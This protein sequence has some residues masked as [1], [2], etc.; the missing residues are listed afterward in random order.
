MEA[1]KTNFTI[2]LIHRDSP[3]SPLYNSSATPYELMKRAAL[4]S[5][6]R[7][8]FFHSSMYIDDKQYVSSLTEYKGEYFIEIYIGSP[9]ATFLVIADTGSS[10]I[11]V[12]CS[13]D[14]KS[15]DFNPQG[16]S[17]YDTIPYNSEFCKALRNINIGDANTCKY[18]R[19][20]YKDGSYTSG[21]LSK[22]TFHLN[23]TSSGSH[24]FPGV[25]FGCSKEHHIYQKNSQVQGFVGLG[26]GVLSFVSQLKSHIESKFS[27]CLLPIGSRKTNKMRFGVGET[28]Y[29]VE[30]VSTPLVLRDPSSRY[31]LSLQSISIG[32]KRTITSQ[33]QVDDLPKMVFHFDGADIHLESAHTFMKYHTHVIC[34]TIVPND[35]LSIFGS[36]SQSLTD[37]KRT[38]F[39][40]DLIHRD[41]PLSPFYDPSITQSERMKNATL[42]SLNRANFFHSSMHINGKRV[43]SPLIEIEGEYIMKIY[44]GYPPIEFLAIADT[45]NNLIWTQCA[46]SHINH[47][48]NGKFFNPLQ[49]TTYDVVPYGSEF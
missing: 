6:S 3:L 13:Q 11:W 16:S 45:R 5:Y 35:K 17:T 30:V 21:I 24:P 31:Y 32:G 18:D 48:R 39:S 23:S 4:R 28:I 2:D 20:S 29:G 36:L 43:M 22:D 33:I 19:Q 12:K 42:H 47:H 46:S 40:I 38:Y 25:V 1:N 14:Y 27:Y 34:M 9:P 10:L 15:H 41:S 44:I 8:N 37:R 49:S 7:A 26:A